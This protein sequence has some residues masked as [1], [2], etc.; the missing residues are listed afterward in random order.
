[1]L[2]AEDEKSSNV[3]SMERQSSVD[4]VLGMCWNTLSDTFEFHL[5]FHRVDRE[6]LNRIRPPTKRELLGIIMA[7][8]DPFGFLANLTICMKILQQSLWKRQIDWDDPLPH[9][10]YTQWSTWW[11]GFQNIAQFTIPRCYSPL[12]MSA[13]EIQLH[14]FVDAS[15][16]AF[17]AVAYLRITKG[18]AVD[19]SF[20]AAKA[21]C[22]PMKGMTIPRLELQ[23]AV[24]GNRLERSIRECHEFHI[25]RVT[26]W[27]DSKTVLLWIR[28]TT[29]EYKQFVASRIAEILGNTQPSQWRWL[30]SSLNIA[31]EA[32][33]AKAVP[34]VCSSSRLLTGPAFLRKQEIAWPVEP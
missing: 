22:A 32:T 12:L 7:I 14:V 34:V 13:D 3:F 9:Q 2:S 21:R 30:P 26:F 15:A 11:E 25:S 17:A 6:V 28:S 27:S 29:R 1:M 4:K 20:V 24:L 31:D 16:S 5:K 10:F 23:A 18:S 19:I 33:R 8:Y